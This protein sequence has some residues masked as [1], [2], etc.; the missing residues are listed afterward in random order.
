LKVGGGQER[1]FD[2]GAVFG[3][4]VGVDHDAS[5]CELAVFGVLEEIEAAERKVTVIFRGEG[6]EAE[7][8][9]AETAARCLVEDGLPLRGPFEDGGVV[10][11]VVPDGF[12]FFRVP[13]GV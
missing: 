8:D 4:E 5:Y 10:G 9:A 3:E 13:P 1:G 7:D 2:P 12:V 11:G 6:A